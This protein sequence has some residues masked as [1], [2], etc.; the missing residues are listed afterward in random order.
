MKARTRAGRC[1]RA[2]GLAIADLHVAAGGN[3]PHSARIEERP[4]L[5]VAREVEADPVVSF[6]VAERP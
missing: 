2:R 3:S 4:L 1:P 5:E 6:E